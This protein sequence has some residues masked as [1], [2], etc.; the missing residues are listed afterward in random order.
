MMKNKFVY[1]VLI[2]LACVLL[3][4]SNT[5]KKGISVVST[6]G[7]INDVVTFIGGDHIHAVGLMGPGV[8]PHL[9]KATE[10]DMR[11]LSEADLI[12]YNGLHLEAKMTDVLEKMSLRKP[13]LEV[14]RTIPRDQLMT[15]EAFEGLYDP[16]V[17]FDVSLW[18]YT[19]DEISKAL[20]HID[21]THSEEYQS[22]ATLLKQQ[23]TE[24]DTW[25]RDIVQ[26]V[27]EN[28]R[29][30]VTAHDAF[31]YF[32]KAYGFEVKGLQGIST[33]SEAGAKDVIDLAR[34]IVQHQLNAIFIESSISEKNVKAVKAAV[35][36]DGWAVTIG[37]ELFSDALGDAD[38]KEGTYIGMVKHNVE[39]IVHALKEEE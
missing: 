28:K 6:T 9:Y 2:F 32:G 19:I 16:H 17:W 37:G 5:Q 33:Q 25:I 20:A 31:G 15:P 30:L 36:S 4:C 21:P 22:R 29:I 34:Y 12:C 23:F 27:P 18:M 13:V 35:L 26:Q 7:M 11:R 39:T 24:L 3:S 8:D 38:A 1:G 10:G 14:T